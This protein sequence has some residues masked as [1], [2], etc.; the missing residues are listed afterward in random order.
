M[1]DL[2]ISL[3][4]VSFLFLAIGVSIFVQFIRSFV[5]FFGKR[6]KVPEVISDFYKHV[7]LRATPPFVGVIICFFAD[8]Y[9]YPEQFA[10]DSG[11]LFFGLVAGLF[12]LPIYDIVKKYIKKAKEKFKINQ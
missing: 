7:L 11:R 3:F 9:P 6:I 2:I 12:A 8:S 1:E 10:T 5:N 4:N